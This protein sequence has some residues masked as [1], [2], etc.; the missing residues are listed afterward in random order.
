M[1]RNRDERRNQREYGGM[2]FGAPRLL[3][4]ISLALQITAPT[5]AFCKDEAEEC[6]PNAVSGK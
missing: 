4:T 6:I 1:C 3:S 2:W 5:W